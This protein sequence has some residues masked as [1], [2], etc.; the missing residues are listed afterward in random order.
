[1]RRK[2]ERKDRDK[3]RDQL[4][5]EL[6]R[7][8]R[9]ITELEMAG[10]ASCGPDRK[11]GQR[12]QCFRPLIED[13][14]DGIV[15]L[16]ADGSFRYRSPAYGRILGE[17]AE[18]EGASIYDRMH[19]DDRKKIAIELA[20]L[21]DGADGPL[22]IEMRLRRDDGSWRIVEATAG[23]LIDDAAVGAIVLNLRDVTELR[24]A[25][26]LLKTAHDE[27]SA[28]PGRPV[29]EPAKGDEPISGRPSERGAVDG[30]LRE[31]AERF[32][33]LIENASDGIAILNPDGTIAYEAPSNRRILGYSPDE[34]PSVTM[35]DRVHPDDQPRLAED[36]VRLVRQ[37]GAVVTH[38]YRARHKDGSW[39][40]IE[41]VGTNL[42]EDPRIRGVVVNFRNVAERNAAAEAVRASEE[43]FRTI[44]ESANDGFIYLDASGTILDING[45]LESMFQRRRDEVVGKKFSDLDF[46]RAD[47]VPGLVD[48][49]MATVRTGEA[50][51]MVEMEIPRGDG[52]SVIIEASTSPVRSDG[53][54]QGILAVVRDATERRRAEQALRESEERFRAL[55]EHAQ[56]AI[57][58]LNQD[59][60]L[61][62]ESPAAARMV[63][64]EVGST[65][66][67]TSFELVHPDDMPRVQE[68]LNSLLTRPG[69]ASQME[70]RVQ[71]RDGSW[72][73]LE[74]IATN[75]L[76]FGPVA[77]IVVNQRDVT[78]RKRAE[79]A[80][81]E[82]EEKW[83]A[84]VS[85]APVHVLT[86][87]PNGRILYVNRTFAGLTVEGVVGTSCYDYV[88]PKDRKR[89]K[90]FV[91]GVFDS[92]RPRRY[93]VVV[94]APSGEDIWLDTILVPTLRDKTVVEAIFLATDITERKREEGEL[95]RYAAL[96]QDANSELAQQG[97]IV[98]HDILLPL[99]AIRYY[100]HLLRNEADE[101]S[102]EDHARHLDMI[103]SAVT[104]GKELAQNLMEI[105][106]SIGEIGH[107]MT[108]VAEGKTVMLP[109]L[110]QYINQPTAGIAQVELSERERGALR[111]L[112]EGL[113]YSQ[114]GQQLGVSAST[115]RRDTRRAME[116]LRLG[117]RKEV[118]A[119][120]ARY[121]S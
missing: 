75:L 32:R 29:T 89:V 114:M 50:L 81:H 105:S 19:P 109:S 82:A 72:R 49:F 13:A 42:V 23:N 116:K 94:S 107:A 76:H 34:E 69:E 17:A 26:R 118:A 20:R 59:G 57:T 14:S 5:K 110:A 111:L 61:R 56:D 1:M 21:R 62:Y 85:N 78:D 58:V 39:Q 90:E 96:L 10:S 84:V 117:S 8:R 48:R 88:P 3:S 38:S 22:H 65:L 11:L 120:A 86:I 66:G 35:F 64:H 31:T 80:L 119:Y 43:K 33:A 106:R 91:K 9:R 115:V 103:D 99:L 53:R 55:V 74:V 27:V 46:L 25:D 83:R 15:I 93:E 2:T 98:S 4:I 87:A 97:E 112:A 12:A 102:P 71:H 18:H 40:T 100:T 73:T 41:A 28:P 7:M 16:D 51:G 44:F 70:V 113:T 92:G 95:R 54:V 63:G 24:Q 101:V 37:P 45:K 60:S 121:L 108:G 6:D 77:G 47:D 52:A 67:K 68:M 30:V 79:Q 104:E 36:F